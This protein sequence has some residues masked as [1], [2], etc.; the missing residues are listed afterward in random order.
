MRNATIFAL[1]TGTLAL[2]AAPASADFSGQP[3]L[4][5]LTLGSVVSGDTTGKADDNDGFDSGDH[6][7][8]IWDGGDDVWQLDWAGGTLA[9]SLESFGGSDNDLFI[10]SPG[11]YDSTGT[12]SIVGGADIDVVTI[13]GAPAGTYF[14]NVDT[15]FFSEGAYELSVAPAPGAAAIL[16]LG[17][18]GAARRRR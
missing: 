1:A 6:F 13:F 17:L 15:T 18:I 2:A 12:Y 8:F 9:V 11:S 16:G 7:F 4:G 5:P 10:Y 3:I 14:I